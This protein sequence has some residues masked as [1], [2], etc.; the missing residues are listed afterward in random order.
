MRTP[1]AFCVSVCKSAKSSEGDVSETDPSRLRE[2]EGGGGGFWEKQ[3][4]G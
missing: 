2:G 4:G 3:K 1:A